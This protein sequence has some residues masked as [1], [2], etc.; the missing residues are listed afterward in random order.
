[1]DWNWWNWGWAKIT[2]EDYLLSKLKTARNQP[3]NCLFEGKKRDIEAE[4]TYSCRVIV[5]ISR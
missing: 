4:N 1:L 2:N 5:D 3:N